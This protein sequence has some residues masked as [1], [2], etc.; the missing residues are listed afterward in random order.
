MLVNPA[1]GVIGTMIPGE[2]RRSPRIVTALPVVLT[3]SDR[4]H[5][6]LLVDVA[7]E[8][9]KVECSAK[10]EIGTRLILKCGTIRAT[11]ILV[12]GEAGRYGIE[13]DSSL[14]KAEVAEQVSRS[15]A[16][17]LRRRLRFHS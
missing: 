11:A 13:F 16:M 7:L 15:E 9:A 5:S 17:G 10:L 12:W 2:E 1:S 3:A 14:T 4:D 8:G 6:A